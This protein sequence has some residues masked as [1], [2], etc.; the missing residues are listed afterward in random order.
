[1]LLWWDLHKFLTWFFQEMC[2]QSWVAE[3]FDASAPRG[4]VHS[5]CAHGQRSQTG[6]VMIFVVVNFICQLDGA[7]G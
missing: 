4:A 1:M 6:V 3:T 2:A 7:F 5:H